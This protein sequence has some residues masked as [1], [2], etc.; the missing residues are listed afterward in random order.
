MDVLTEE[1]EMLKPLKY[2]IVENKDSCGQET[3]GIILGTKASERTAARKETELVKDYILLPLW[4]A[5]PPYSQ[6]P[7]SSHDDGSK[8]SS[9]DGNK[10]NEDP[11]K[12]SECKDQKS[13]SN[14]EGVRL[15]YCKLLPQGS[16]NHACFCSSMLPCDELTQV[17]RQRLAVGAGLEVVVRYILHL[18]LSVPL[19]HNMLYSLLSRLLLPVCCVL[20]VWGVPFSGGKEREG[21]GKERGGGEGGG[22]KKGRDKRGKRGKKRKE[23]SERRRKKGKKRRKKNKKEERKKRERKIER[24]KERRERKKEE[25]EVRI[26][27]ENIEGKKEK[28]RNRK[29]LV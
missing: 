21:R 18:L 7:K 28:D 26:K 29:N 2:S 4:T 8:P 10:V 1:R 27:R 5:D 3:L 11:R 6:D 23:S 13:E 20:D 9:D 19:E 17:N 22:R 16:K 24:K 25:E 15:R 12:D 14:I